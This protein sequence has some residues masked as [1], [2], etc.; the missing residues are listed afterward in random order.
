MYTLQT[1]KSLN[2][3]C[4]CIYIWHIKQCFADRGGKSL[5][6]LSSNVNERRAESQKPMRRISACH[7]IYVYTV[8]IC[9]YIIHLCALIHCEAL[10]LDANCILL[11]CT[12]DK[13]NDNKV[14]SNYR[15]RFVGNLVFR[16]SFNS[17]KFQNPPC[18]NLHGVAH[19]QE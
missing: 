16:K 6:W 17:L 18:Q 12:C 10:S 4:L 8:Y 7:L 13:C 1:S 14:E 15:F 19:L 5:F 9:I 3:N 11:L 2:S